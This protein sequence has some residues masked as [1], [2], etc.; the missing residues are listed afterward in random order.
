MSWLETIR[1]RL[2]TADRPRVLQE[3]SSQLALLATEPGLRPRLYSDVRI[4]TDLGLHLHWS[5]PE[6]PAEGSAVGRRIAAGLES[7]GLVHH[8]V[9]REEVDQ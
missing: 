9:W 4:P 8:A 3:L 5:G 7:A 6:V 1:V 2:T